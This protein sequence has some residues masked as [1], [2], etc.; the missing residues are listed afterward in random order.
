MTDHNKAGPP[1]DEG[2]AAIADPANV[3]KSVTTP[4]ITHTTP[5]SRRAPAIGHGSPGAAGF[6]EGFQRGAVDALRLMGRRCH[7]LDCAVEAEK[8]TAYYRGA[9]DRR[10]S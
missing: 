2:R 8:L 7:C 1:D 3:D 9:A 4:L 5:A 10:A 6:R